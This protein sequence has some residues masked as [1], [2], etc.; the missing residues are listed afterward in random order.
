MLTNILSFLSNFGYIAIFFLITI[1]NIFPPIPA[2]IILTFSGFMTTISNLTAL[3]V[4]SVATLGSYLGALILYSLGYLIKKERLKKLLSNRSF[5]PQD[6]NRCFDWFEQ[7]GKI[8]VLLGRLIP[9]VRSLISLPAGIMKMN[10]FSF[11]LYTLVG[12]IIWNTV[13]VYLGLMLGNNWLLIS[14]YIKQYA[15]VIAIIAITILLIKKR[16]RH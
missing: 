13:L 10:F 2:E 5:S 3:G 7:Y 9:I 6:L 11:S 16:K 14:K 12:T 15:L 4:I 1:E 8:S